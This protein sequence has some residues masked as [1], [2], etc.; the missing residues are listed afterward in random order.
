MKQILNLR[1]IETM[2]NFLRKTDYDNGCVVWKGSKSKR[3]YGSV[4][5]SG[6]SLKAHRVSYSWANSVDI[7]DGM[8]V[9]HACDNPSCVNPEHLWLGTPRENVFDMFKKGRYRIVNSKAHSG[10]RLSEDDVREIVRLKESGLGYKKIAKLYP[11]DRTSIVG[12]IL[13]KTWTHV[14]GRTYQQKSN[15]CPL[16]PITN[17]SPE[18]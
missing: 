15:T 14:T 16:L 12:I 6:V 11:V 2:Q 5:V 10:T 9:C 1:N 3:G 13:G 8:H 17:E 4:S 18:Q 7:P